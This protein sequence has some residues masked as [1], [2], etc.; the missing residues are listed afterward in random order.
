L[1][2][3]LFMSLAGI[4]A[5]ILAE[6]EKEKESIIMAA[7]S[8][9]KKLQKEAE[10][11]SANLN[12]NFNKEIEKSKKDIHEQARIRGELQAR[13]SIL[14]KK[15][16]LIDKVFKKVLEDLSEKREEEKRKLLSRFLE[17]AR[18]DLGDE[19]TILAVKKDYEVIRGLA[20]KHQKV[21]VSNKFARG[22]GG[23]IAASQEIEQDYTL[24]NIVSEKQEKLESEVA[25][26]LFG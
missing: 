17:E 19:I 13:N 1:Y 6:A 24:D 21:K 22:K 3:N 25:K 26:I 7:K 10:E 12:Q 14:K 9:A 16:E 15:Q 8:E 5:K 20:G 2:F 11:K 23:F 18:N 4:K